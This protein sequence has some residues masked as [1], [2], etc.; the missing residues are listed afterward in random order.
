MLMYCQGQEEGEG[1][2]SAFLDFHFSPRVSTWPDLTNTAV[3]LNSSFLSD[4]RRTVALQ[5]RL[6]FQIIFSLFYICV[7]LLL[8]PQIRC[9]INNN[10]SIYIESISY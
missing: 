3:P 7:L 8:N 2:K 6:Y 4:V 10:C 1:K 5:G 9:F